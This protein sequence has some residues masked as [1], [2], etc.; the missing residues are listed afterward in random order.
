MVENPALESGKEEE[1]L[2][3]KDEFDNNDDDYDD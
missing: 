3:E 2:Y 1:E